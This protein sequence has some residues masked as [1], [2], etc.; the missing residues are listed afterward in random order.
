MLLNK[1]YYICS[2]FIAHTCSIVPFLIPALL[3]YVV[4]HIQLDPRSTL[5]YFCEHG[6]HLSSSPSKL[7]LPLNEIYEI[8][9]R[10]EFLFSTMTVQ[11]RFRYSDKIIFF[12]F[13]SLS[14]YTQ[15]YSDA[16]KQHKTTTLM[17][18]KSFSSDRLLQLKYVDNT[19]I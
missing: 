14:M 7:I 8:Q 13:S 5:Q 16:H 15:Q 17:P 10:Q 12:H 1:K 2:Q 18:I 9:L 19:S 6:S 11:Y 3:R 4:L